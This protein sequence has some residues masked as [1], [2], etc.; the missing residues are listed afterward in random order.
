MN[1]PQSDFSLQ[2]AQYLQQVGN[3]QMQWANQEYA[4][5][6]AVTDAQINNYI[7]TAQQGSDLAGGMLG[8]YN[9]LYAPMTDQYARESGTYASKG[10]LQHEMG[11]AQSGV[12]QAG[13]AAKQ[14]AEDQLASFGID[15]SSG[16]YQ[17]L[18]RASNTATAA[19][20]AGAGEQAR[21]QT[22]MEGTR[23]RENAIAMGQQL[24]GASVNA[25]N[26][27]Y[28]G[29]AGATN[30]ALGLANTG[31]NLRTSAS[32]FYDPAMSLRPP[33]LGQNSQSSGQQSSMSSSPPPPGG[34]GASGRG[35]GGGDGSGGGGR[36]PGSGGGGYSGGY[37]PMGGYGGAGPAGAGGGGIGGYYN[38]GAGIRSINPGPGGPGIINPD[39]NWGYG[40]PSMDY[41]SVVNQYGDPI[42]DAGAGM[43]D[44][45]LGNIDWNSYDYG[46]PATY[47]ETAG[48]TADVWGSGGNL[49]NFNS[50][51]GFQDLNSY[52]GWDSYQEPASSWADSAPSY[53]DWS[54][55][56]SDWGDFAKGG[57]VGQRPGGGFVPPQMSPSGGQQTDDVAA[58]IP[59]TGGRAQINVGEF[60][61]PEDVVRWKGQEHF[62]KL[63]TQA[64]KARMSMSAKPQRG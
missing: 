53:G 56:G 17:D 6:G 39:E 15:P 63:I 29:I 52:G 21:R 23:R 46:Q 44:Q 10:R 43:G 25:L 55:D 8:R 51:S 34:S 22:E 41:S 13:E 11:R 47:D 61:M 38:G 2:L 30:A 20:A 42:F 3:Q 26:S 49:D 19:A 48:G 45:G 31:V 60:V 28:Q 40:D 33:P 64:R 18:V 9:N 5:A 12:M 32:R 7:A 58:V 24:P 59:Q 37:N 14:K 16:R 62:Q 57:A 50:G 35:S 36:S 54:G 4:R 1:T 27:A